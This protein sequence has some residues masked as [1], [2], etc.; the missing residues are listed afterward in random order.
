MKQILHLTGLLASIFLALAA[1]PAD[2]GLILQPGAASTDMG[3]SVGSTDNVINQSGLSDGY[4][5]LAT[6]FDTY[7]AGTPTHDNTINLNHWTSALS[8]TS[9]NFDFDLG[10]N[11]TI[12]S[13]A[14][15][16]NAGTN[17]VRDFTLLVDDNAG[18]SSPTSLGSFTVLIT[19]FGPQNALLSQ[20]FSFAATSA[21]FVRMQVANNHGGNATTF[22]EA[23]FEV[24][25][26]TVPEPSA[27]ALL[28][29][30][31]LA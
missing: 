12:E 13:F 25:S 8:T 21:S 26:Q 23:A 10:G 2:A 3:T 9:G 7:T 30:G 1:A 20:V 17:G 27:L 5:S 6:N 16:N 4:T 22:G 29:M 19:G 28:G 14:L 18:F 24:Q 15:W 11:F 31:S